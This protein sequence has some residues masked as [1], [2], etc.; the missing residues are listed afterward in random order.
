MGRVVH[1]GLAS[2]TVKLAALKDWQP[3][4]SYS[5]NIREFREVM[6]MADDGRLTPIP[7]EVERRERINDVHHRLETGQIRR[8]AVITP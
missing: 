2:G 8:R 1:V 6:D 5:G 3:E 7:L 4:V